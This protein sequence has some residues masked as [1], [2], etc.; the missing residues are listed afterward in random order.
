MQSAAGRSERLR[1]PLE[2]P[3]CDRAEL[4]A[5]LR[6]VRTS[7]DW[8][9][10]SLPTGLRRSH[11]LGTGTWGRI[12][13]HQGRL[14]FSMASQPPLQHELVRGDEQA[15]PPEMDHEV[16]PIGSVRF[17]LDFLA[18]DRVHVTHARVPVDQGGDPACWSGV[19]QVWSHPRRVRA[20]LRLF[21]SRAHL[22]QTELRGQ[23]STWRAP[24]AKGRLA[25]TSEGRQGLNAAILF[26]RSKPK[27]PLTHAHDIVY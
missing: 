20:S 14:E 12:Q 2:C 19:P 7:P 15:I 9:E 11:R 24:A 13:V 5:N 17:S 4:P 25:P 26:E 8:N 23:I 22:M 27:A 21:R 10:L 3:L 16:R 1:Q 6:I 18:V